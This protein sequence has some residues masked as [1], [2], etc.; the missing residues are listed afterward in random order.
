MCTRSQV[1]TSKGAVGLASISS[2]LSDWS[3]AAHGNR[4]VAKASV[5]GVR[6]SVPQKM[7]DSLLCW[8]SERSGSLSRKLIIC[9]YL[10]Q[11]VRKDE[12]LN[13]N[14]DPH[15]KRN[16]GLAKPPVISL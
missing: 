13:L 1:I 5:G 12:G 15:Y 3:A 9:H 8:K 10:Y 11:V 4:L 2:L 16:L 14:T 7:E 6:V